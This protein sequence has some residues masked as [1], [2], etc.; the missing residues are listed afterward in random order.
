MTNEQVLEKMS[1]DMQ[2][3]NFSHYTYYSYMHKGKEIISFF[4]KSIEK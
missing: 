3:R 1:K 2:M 4:N